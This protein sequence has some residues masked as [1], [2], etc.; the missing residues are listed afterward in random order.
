VT[1]AERIAS[2]Q[3]SGSKKLNLTFGK[4]WWWSEKHTAKSQQAWCVEGREKLVSVEVW[5][6]GE[7][8]VL[9][10]SSLENKKQRRSVF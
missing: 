6:Q 3:S 5:K 7:M 10:N 8:E 1:I 2:I 9:K 4:K